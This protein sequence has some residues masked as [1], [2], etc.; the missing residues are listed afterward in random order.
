MNVSIILESNIL[1]NYSQI[2]TTVNLFQETIQVVRIES[3]T[4]IEIEIE[5]VE[6]KKAEKEA[7]E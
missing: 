3:I 2:K 7:K 6:R 5:G 4:I 1:T